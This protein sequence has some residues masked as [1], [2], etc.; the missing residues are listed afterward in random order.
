MLCCMLQSMLAALVMLKILS[1]KHES[2]NAFLNLSTD[3]DCRFTVHN[4]NIIVDS[5]IFL[6]V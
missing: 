5:S 2:R 4:C 3:S 1:H 6:Y